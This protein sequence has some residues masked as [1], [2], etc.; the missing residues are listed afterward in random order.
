[1][2]LTLLKQLVKMPDRYLVTMVNRGRTYWD[3]E[4]KK[5]V[6][7][8]GVNVQHCK[9]DRKKDGFVQSV[10]SHVLKQG[11]PLSGVIDFSAF[12]EEQ[13]QQVIDIVSQV[14]AAGLVVQSKLKYVFISTD[15]TYDASAFMLD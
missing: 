3:G 14:R 2:G 15:S 7:T 13:C 4:S 9:A 11:L 8:P 1:M 6:K 10:T 12:R 5:I